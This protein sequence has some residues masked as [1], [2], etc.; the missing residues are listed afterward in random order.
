MA[1][2]LAPAAT[3]DLDD[4]W[5]YAAR[6]S[7]SLEVA[8]KMIDA[9]TERFWLISRH[10]HIGRGRDDDW[11]AG[12]RSFPVG[13][14]VIIYRTEDEDVVILRVLRGSRDIET[15]FRETLFRT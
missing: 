2:R 9:I 7:G 14:Y 10:P 12:L 1:H 3:F 15:L 8:D 6:E 11:R 4:I 13:K 5:F